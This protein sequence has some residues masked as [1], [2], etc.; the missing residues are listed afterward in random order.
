MST[1]IRPEISPKN[2]YWLTKHRYYEL[3]HFCL[4]YSTWKKAYKAL[5]GLSTRPFDFET[6]IRNGNQDSNPTERCAIAKT[7][8]RERMAMVEQAAWEADP[9]LKQYLIRAVTE[10]L[11]YE[12]LRVMLGIPCCKD[13]YYKIY[14]RFFWLLSQ[15]R[16]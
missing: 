5:D 8:Y 16:Q 10:G 12:T 9:E 7:Y 4:Q 15:A 3:K 11:S 1:V 13:N 2:E 6:F 14:R